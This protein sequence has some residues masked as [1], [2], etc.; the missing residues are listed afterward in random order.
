MAAKHF[1]S[2]ANV[3]LTVACIA[4]TVLVVE[5]LWSERQATPNA[6]VVQAIEDD[7][8]VEV[9][10]LASEGAADAKVLL[11]EF[12]DF[13]CPF[14]GSFARDTHTELRRDYIETGKVRH[15]FRHYPLP[16]HAS[17]VDAAKA[18]ECA[19]REGRYWD[20]YE[21]L[22]A[23]QRM[24]TP[25]HLAGYAKELGIDFK[26]FASCLGEAEIDSRIAADRKEAA[27]LKVVSTP[28]FFVGIR[29]NDGRYQLVRRVNGAAPYAVFSEVIDGLNKAPGEKALRGYRF[30]AL[31]S[32]FW[33]STTES[34][35]CN[36]FLCML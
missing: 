12:S 4:L 23:N 30:E 13:E 32:L 7:V 11:L 36:S 10:S 21:R 22:F 8:V 28:T 3:A 26:R 16:I 9:Q 19:L 31:L 17:A 29:Q 5:R 24:L 14:C 15:I 25:E 35:S 27:R 33:Q 1:E 34:R 18:A 20:M 2:T 6:Q